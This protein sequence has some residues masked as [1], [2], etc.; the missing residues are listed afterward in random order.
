M[1]KMSIPEISYEELQK[2]YEHIKPVINVDGKLHYFRNFT[3]DELTQVSFLFERNI[4]DEVLENELEVIEGKDFPCLHGYGYYGF[5]KPSI[6]EV[7]SQ[8]NSNVLPLVKAFEIIEYPETT[9][10]FTKDS[11]TYIA[12]ENGFHVSTVRLYKEKE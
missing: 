2:R 11:F 6:A 10:N 4:G 7:L 3:T 1:F 12:F 9:S 8:I 5:F